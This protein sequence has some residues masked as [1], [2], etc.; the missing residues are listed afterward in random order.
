M[1]DAEREETEEEES[2]KRER[3]GSV[4]QKPPS[5]PPKGGKLRSLWAEGPGE[6]KEQAA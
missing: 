3:E 5:R 2:K 1:R 4:C 6:N